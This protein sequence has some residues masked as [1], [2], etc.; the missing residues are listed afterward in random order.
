MLYK[1]ISVLKNQKLYK[2]AGKCDEQQQLKETLEA[3]MVSTPEGFIYGSP[4]SSMTST[5]VKKP[6]ARTSLCLFTN[7]LYVKE[8]IIPIELELLNKSTSQ[9]NMEIHHGH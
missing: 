3:A 9:L 6:R 4:R 1:N 5:P 2:Q 8:K 7:I